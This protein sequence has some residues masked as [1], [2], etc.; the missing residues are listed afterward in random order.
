VTAVGF[1]EEADGALL[2]AAGGPA[3]AWAHNLLADAACRVTIAERS[4]AATASLLDRPETERAVVALILR[5]GTPA[6]RLGNGPA[7]RLTPIPVAA[8]DP[9]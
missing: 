4:F 1:V 8:T 6:E 2:I 7:F 5:Y 3:T 9:A